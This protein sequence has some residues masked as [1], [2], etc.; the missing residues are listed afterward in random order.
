MGCLGA[1]EAWGPWA[2]AQRAHWIRR[3]CV[4]LLH[5]Y[6]AF[7][8]HVEPFHPVTTNPSPEVRGGLCQLCFIRVS[9]QS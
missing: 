4:A 7:H 2:R 1:P 3:P 6:R 9:Y 5:I 8:C